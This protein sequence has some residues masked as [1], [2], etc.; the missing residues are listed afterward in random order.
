MS[1]VTE[2]LILLLAAIPIAFVSSRLRQPVIVAFMLTGI[3]IGP[4]G[5]GLVSDVASVEA[6]AEIGVVLLLFTIG[7]EFSVKRMMEMR[8]LVLLGGGLQVCL[9]I[10]LVGGIFLLFGRAPSLAIYFGFL[11][12]LSSTAIVLKTY[13]DRGEIDTPYGKVAVGSLS[14]RTFASCP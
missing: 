14:S 5:L 11:F 4:Y 2:L 8:K 1:L 6:L 13:L 7:L 10:A 12:A 9:T 3:I